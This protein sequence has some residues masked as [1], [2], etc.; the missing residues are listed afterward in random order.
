MVAK[1]DFNAPKH[2]DIDVPNL[3]VIKLMQSLRSRQY[4]KENFNWGWYYW[5]LTNE[6]IEYLRDY[7]HLPEEIVP[8][9]LRKPRTQTRP[10][11]GSSSRG[12]APARGEEKKTAPSADFKPDYVSASLAS[13]LTFFFFAARTGCCSWKRGLQKGGCS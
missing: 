10:S 11:V 1:K 2:H 3:Y 6:G 8:D 4:V 9:T 7:L 12:P 13:E 5:F